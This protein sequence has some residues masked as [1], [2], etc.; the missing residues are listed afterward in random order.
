[1]DKSSIIHVTIKGR[2]SKGYQTTGQQASWVWVA[3]QQ[4]KDICGKQKC[5]QDIW[6]GGKSG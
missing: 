1:M 2:Y 4:N 3:V 6:L 5:W